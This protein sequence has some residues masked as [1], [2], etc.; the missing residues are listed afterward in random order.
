MSRASEYTEE[1]ADEICGLLMDGLSLRRICLREEMPD[2][3][4]VLRWLE[5]RPEFAARCARARAM[6][7]DLM[8]DLVLDTAESS[9][10]ETAASDRV[11]I[12]AYQWRAAKLAPKKYGDRTHHEH[13]GANGGPIRTQE[14]SHY[15]DERLAAL[16]ALVGADTDAGGSASGDPAPEGSEGA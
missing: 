2:R 16:A 15:S 1:T 3:R 9:T 7:A 8:D 6:Q 5:A 13:T 14:L 11:K 4:T 12:S 10:P